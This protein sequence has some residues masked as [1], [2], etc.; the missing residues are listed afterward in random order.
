WV[1]TTVEAADDAIAR[2]CAE[3]GVPCHRGSEMDVLDRVTGAAC[4]AGADYLVQMGADSAY[5]DF[6]L[7]DE[8]VAIA[9]GGDYDYVCNDLQLTWPLGIYCHVVRV[10]KLV[11]LNARH[12][13]S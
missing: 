13:L 7:I 11:Q 10:E 1:A 8:M 6:Q 2:W 12:D 9:R 3:Y 5:L 4:Q